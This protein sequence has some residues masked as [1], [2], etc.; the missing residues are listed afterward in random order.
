MDFF[1]YREI[2]RLGGKDPYSA[3]KAMAENII[4]SYFLIHTLEIQISKLALLEHGNVI[5]G[6][7]WAKNRLIP[8]CIRAGPI[9]GQ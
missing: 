7:D 1:R 4:Y 6:G 2:D 3:S 8:D 5:G 9:E